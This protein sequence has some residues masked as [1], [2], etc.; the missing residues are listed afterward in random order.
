MALNSEP[1]PLPPEAWDPRLREAARILETELPTPANV[2]IAARV[3]LSEFHFTRLFTAQ[4]GRSPQA[5][6]IDLRLR[7]AAGRL[8]YTD[9][10]PQVIARDFG[11]ASQA[12]FTRAFSTRYGEPPARFRRRI[13][14]EA[15]ADVA[16][17]GAREVRLELFK[18]Q[19]LFARRYLGP[20]DLSSGQW[21]D[22][23]TRLPPELMGCTRTGLLYDDP[24]ETLAEQIRYD[25]A[26]QVRPDTPLPPELA[27]QG[28]ERITTPGG[29]W[30]CTDA[31][32]RAAVGPAYRRIVADWKPG[33]PDRTF[34]GDP[35]LERFRVTPED[36]AR[37]PVLTVCLRVRHPAEPPRPGL[38]DG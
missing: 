13:R 31:V 36:P 32:G 6:A 4:A 21:A 12:T 20:R 7:G 22:F 8:R 30:A 37:E 14:A 19:A 9:D 2:D 25:C 11:W 1:S 26:V 10:P 3:G 33:R 15:S 34:E 5:Y 28:F 23:L 35:H 38:A 17:G 24:R 29:E 27:E 18:P 16:A